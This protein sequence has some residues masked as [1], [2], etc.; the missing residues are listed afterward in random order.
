[1]QEHPEQF[2]PLHVTP[3]NPFINHELFFYEILNQNVVL[4]VEAEPPIFPWLRAFLVVA[5]M[6]IWAGSRQMDQEGGQAI[7]HELEVSKFELELDVARPDKDRVNAVQT[8][9]L[10]LE[11]LTGVKEEFN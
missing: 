7:S 6:A 4:S 2:K 10:L 5:G 1:M 8:K 11:Q 9:P 3:P